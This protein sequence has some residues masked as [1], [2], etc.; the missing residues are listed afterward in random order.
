VIDVL[1]SAAQQRASIGAKKIVA[2]EMRESAN[3]LFQSAP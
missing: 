1:R 3:G 2:A